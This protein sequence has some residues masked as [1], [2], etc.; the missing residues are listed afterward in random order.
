MVFLAAPTAAADEIDPA[1]AGEP[2]ASIV[3]Q[4][5]AASPAPAVASSPAAAPAVASSPAAVPAVASS[6]AVPSPGPSATASVDP[7]AA[8]NTATAT[9][10]SHLTSPQNLPPGTTDAAPQAPT[11]LGYLRDVLQAIRSEDVTM[12]DAL[13]LLAQRPMDAKPTAGSSLAA[14]PSAPTGTSVPAAVVAPAAGT[15]TP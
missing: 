4:P 9:P 2:A 6:P 5:D 13:L 7:A 11:R 15:D 12:S 1:A 3:A 10:V 14:G 8:T